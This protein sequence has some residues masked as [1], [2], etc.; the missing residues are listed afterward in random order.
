MGMLHKNTTNPATSL[1]T[2]AETVVYTT[3]N[4]MSGIPQQLPVGIEGTVNVTPGTAATGITVRVRQSSLTGPV[5]GQA[6]L[7]TVAAGAAQSISFGATDN[8]GFL[9]GGGVYVVTLQ[10]TA[11]T[12]NGTVNMVDIGV[13]ELWHPLA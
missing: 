12:G 3:P 4:L 11:A 1:V 13:I 8:T 5:V 10:Q 6:P 2:T 7:H 9:Q